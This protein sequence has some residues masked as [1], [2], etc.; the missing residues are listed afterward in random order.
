[1]ALNRRG[2]GGSSAYTGPRSL[3][4]GAKIGT[5]EF[6]EQDLARISRSDATD[7]LTGRAVYELGDL[8]VQA[9]EEKKKKKKGKLDFT[10]QMPD[11]L[12]PG[13]AIK[14]GDM[15]TP[16]TGE[17]KVPTSTVIKQEQEVQKQNLKPDPIEPTF[18]TN[19][20]DKGAQDDIF[21]T[22]QTR[23]AQETIDPSVKG[24]PG[25]NASLTQSD[26][27]AA[28]P[29]SALY[30]MDLSLLN[31]GVSIMSPTSGP[32][33]KHKFSPLDR[34]DP[35]MEMEVSGP[36]E[37]GVGHNEAARSYN[38]GVKKRNY[39]RAVWN[40]HKKQLDDD[41]TDL[42]I[43]PGGPTSLAGDKAALA[44]DIYARWQDL[45]A[46]RMDR[47]PME[48][49]R[50]EEGLK[51]EAKQINQFFTNLTKNV[52]DWGD[53][54]DNVSV[55]TPFN[56]IDILNS[57]RNNKGSFDIVRD[58]D[59][60]QLMFKGLTENGQEV[61]M[62]VSG[63]ASGENLFRYNTKVDIY[64]NLLDPLT[65]E[66]EKY[67][68]EYSTKYGVEK[69]LIPFEKMEPRIDARLNQF[70]NNSKN[71][72]SVLADGYGYSYEDQKE[73][74]ARGMN[75]KQ[76]A[77][78]L[79]KSD[80]QK[81][82]TPAREVVDIQADP[83]LAAKRATQA[84]PPKM[85]QKQ[86]SLAD[87]RQQIDQ[88]GQLSSKNIQQYNNKIGKSGYKVREKGGKYYLVTKDKKTGKLIGTPYSDELFIQI[89]AKEGVVPQSLPVL[90][91]N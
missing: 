30:G 57:I 2:R 5:V 88:I 82:L 45:Q 76:E 86:K 28:H 6:S 78:R 15:V 37:L 72:N 59:T 43:E 44:Q 58:K 31:N 33:R 39:Q 60:G 3:K 62:P 42:K 38:I 12:D 81:T 89:Y 40:S 47:D 41:F 52:S 61:D 68:S 69:R 73:M 50:L 21:P 91:K 53:D 87:A 17:N 75:L 56:T 48:Q 36:G 70:L 49:K 14:Y 9:A 46:G 19:V 4:G 66:L 71:I 18:V 54:L 24:T 65:T 29:G 1:M 20:F 32:P 67:K 16:I 34:L 80:L 55:G 26:I 10:P 79:L 25:Y 7:N 35:N 27:N 83:Q 90:N 85:T 74:E 77:A 8:A 84:K 22:I 63:I 51:D 23:T 13:N 11:P 64:G